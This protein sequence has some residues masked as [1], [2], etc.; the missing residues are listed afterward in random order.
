MSVRELFMDK[1]LRLGVIAALATLT[2][3]SAEALLL[4]PKPLALSSTWDCRSGPD[5][6]WLCRSSQTD[7]YEKPLE[8]AAYSA[9]ER[10]NEY[11]DYNPQK[12]TRPV[13]AEPEPYF[14]QEEAPQPSRQPDNYSDPY[15]Q[16]APQQQTQQRVTQLLSA[17]HGSF[18]IQ[19]LATHTEEPLRDLQ[20]RFPVL[21]QATI[22][23]YQ[24]KN[25]DWFVLLDGP[26]L[27]RQSAMT[28]LSSPPRLLMTDK[29]YPWTRSLAS[30]QKLNL[31]M[32][33]EL[34]EPGDPSQPANSQRYAYDPPIRPDSNR[35]FASIAPAYP[36]VQP[37]EP[38]RDYNTDPYQVAEPQIRSSYQS[39]PYAEEPDLNYQEPRQRYA[40]ITPEVD[41]S[42]ARKHYQQDGYSA[43]SAQEEV[44]EYRRSRE[45]RE[46]RKSAKRSILE[47]SRN[48]YAIQWLAGPRRDTLER[49][50]RRYK[51]LSDAQ[52]I[53]YRKGRRDWFLLVGPPHSSKS[54]ANR[55]LSTPELARASTRLYP[56]VR[57][58]NELQNLVTGKPKQARQV[59]SEVV[60][61][62]QG[63]IISGPG[64]SY[65][66][67]WFA[68]NKPEAIEKMK[69][70]FPELKSAVTARYR[71]NQKDWYVLLQG[72]FTNSK[73]ALAVIKS[74]QLKDAARVLHPWTRSVK[75][76]KKLQ[77]WES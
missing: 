50:R 22:V 19:W 36:Q 21:Q 76:L 40:Q 24:R 56:R 14:R 44:S 41:R 1:P 10:N 53:H 23:R 49:V 12:R 20:R 64:K 37:Q 31:I 4:P 57:S 63:T 73:E 29:L 67:Q 62:P 66:I 43:Y 25:K 54:K 77:A 61:K 39:D 70:R 74:P 27:D 33:G 48:S 6:D 2:A 5:S 17:E 45:T 38:Y 42:G 15:R 30:I 52:I 18:V 55:A 11:P 8:T 34:R 16:A 9:P 13:E 68:A 51:E 59:R 28:A 32:P 71:K 72:Q 3:V 65:T 46:Y 26:F 47:A 60:A 58:V 69:K 75:S 7:E 35:L